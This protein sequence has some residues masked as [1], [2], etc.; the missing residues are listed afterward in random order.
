ME[1]AEALFLAG[2]KVNAT[3]AVG[4]TALHHAAQVGRTEMV[5][6]LRVSRANFKQLDTW[7]VAFLFNEKHIKIISILPILYC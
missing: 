3:N 4:R 5:H 6:F 7:Q 1:Q 2:A